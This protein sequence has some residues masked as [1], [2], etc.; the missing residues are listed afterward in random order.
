MKSFANEDQYKQKG[1]YLDQ[2]RFT[3]KKTF[4]ILIR[5]IKVQHQIKNM[6]STCNWHEFEFQTYLFHP[7]VQKGEVWITSHNKLWC[8]MV[9]FRQ[10]SRF[11]L[12]SLQEFWYMYDS[13]K[14]VNIS[15][16]ALLGLAVWLCYT[17]FCFSY[18]Q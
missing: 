16:C 15:H 4:K 18:I 9:Y 10:W 5:N 12:R 11:F 7:I 6:K 3:L 17:L 13:Y 8:N 2:Q 14:W 1:V